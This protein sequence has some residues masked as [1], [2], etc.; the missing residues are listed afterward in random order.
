MEMSLLL[1]KLFA[2]GALVAGLGM[3]LNHKYYQKVF[4]DL[5]KDKKCIFFLAWT[6]LILGLAIVLQHNI[7]VWEWKVAVTLLGW[8]MMV[9]GAFLILFPNTIDAFKNAYKPAWV[10][11]FAGAFYTAIGIVLGYYGFFA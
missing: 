3:L 2:V 5:V 10:L 11:V 9:K 4:T 1:M 8:I 6:I 7:W